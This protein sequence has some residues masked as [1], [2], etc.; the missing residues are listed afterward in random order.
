MKSLYQAAVA[1]LILGLA[2]GVFYRE[3]TRS[4]G[5]TEGQFS[6]LGVT[7]THL[8]MLGF[9]AFLIFLLLEKNF[10]VSRFSKLF[11]SFFWF[12]NIGVVVTVGM[13]LWRGSLTV[14]NME[15]NAMMSG[16]AGLGHISITVGLACF[17]VALGRAIKDPV[18]AKAEKID[19]EKVNA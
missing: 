5:F 10:A 4:Q 19:A 14:L 15:G 13:M 18:P 6:Q 12:Y 16:I 9:F 11:T 17:M 2:S 8:L 7:H 3:F 1:Y